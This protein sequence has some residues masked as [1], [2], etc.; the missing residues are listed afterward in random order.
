M[1]IPSANTQALPPGT[2]IEGFII[3]RV[4]GAGGSGIT[5]LARD[6]RLTVVPRHTQGGDAG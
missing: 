5:Y 3:E 6:T 1:E 4:L 2:R